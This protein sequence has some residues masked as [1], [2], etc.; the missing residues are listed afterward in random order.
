M[1]L[2]KV[3]LAP[4][5]DPNWPRIRSWLN[6]MGVAEVTCLD[7]E[8]VVQRLGQGPPSALCLSLH[9]AVPALLDL[10]G[11]AAIQR[12]PT[13]LFVEAPLEETA[14]DLC[15]VG[16]IDY[17][18]TEALTRHGLRRALE[19][20]VRHG[21]WLHREQQLERLRDQELESFAHI[22]AHDLR[23]P[24]RGLTNYAS[25]L[26]EDF[27]D[28]LG[29]EGL[30]LVATIDR[31]ARRIETMVSALNRYARL[32]HTPL[33]QAEH[34]LVHLITDAVQSQ[35]TSINRAGA[36]VRVCL[37]LP[38][39]VCDRNLMHEVLSA[40]VANAV[41]FNNKPEKWVEIGAQERAHEIVL[42]VRDNGIG[43][44]EQHHLRVFRIFKRLHGRD[45]FGQGAGVGLSLVSQ[46]VRRHGGRIWVESDG[47]RG[48]TFF[49]ALPRRLSPEAIT[50]A[51]AVPAGQ[52]NGDLSSPADD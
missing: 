33:V 35:A 44:P 23:E 38:T 30:D 11:F 26:R 51:E 3:I 12:V 29:I 40:L 36:E 16:P 2:G 45:H 20:T 34:D 32:A 19:R 39:L 48:A 41:S 25:F 15:D 4:A 42:H 7:V 9:A 49:V 31:L 37:P 21:A 17:A 14:A 18:L 10:I 52:G 43:I 24:L 8:A 50:E 27:G 6:E 5:G 28:R 47:D 13:V 22:T 46:I 1:K